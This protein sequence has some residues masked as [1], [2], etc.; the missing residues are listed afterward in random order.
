MEFDDYLYESCI[1]KTQFVDGAYV[2]SFDDKEEDEVIVL[3]NNE[4]VA[5][6]APVKAKEVIDIT[7]ESNSVIHLESEEVE[8]IVLE[9]DS[10]GTEGSDITPIQNSSQICSCMHLHIDMLN[11]LLP[12]PDP[13]F[14]ASKYK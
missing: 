2:Y 13:N 7:S 5:D 4:N 11:I 9:T 6:V 8:V 12:S 1:P 14:W 10:D 3:E